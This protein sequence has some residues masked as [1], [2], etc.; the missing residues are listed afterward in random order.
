MDGEPKSYTIFNNSQIFSK[1]ASY[2]PLHD[3]K[4]GRLV[5]HNW[6]TELGPTLE[7]STFVDLSKPN[8]LQTLRLYNSSIEK[9]ETFTHSNFVIRHDTS[10]SDSAVY[11]V[12][13]LQ[14]FTFMKETYG[15][16]VKCLHIILGD[17][18]PGFLN[19]LLQLVPNLKVL[20]VTC[21]NSFSLANTPNVVNLSVRRK[22]PVLETLKFR[23]EITSQMERR[24]MMAT[25]LTV[26]FRN[27]PHNIKRVEVWDPAIQSGI[28]LAAFKI[29]AKLELKNWTD[30]R[31]PFFGNAMVPVIL[32]LNQRLSVIKV[33]GIYPGSFPS[34][35]RILEKH[36]ATLTI[37]Q[38]TL[39]SMRT[40]PNEAELKSMQTQNFDF[41][42]LPVLKK[43]TCSV[44]KFPQNTS[45]TW[46]GVISLYDR[47]IL[48]ILQIRREISTTYTV[49]FD[50]FWKFV[51]TAVQLFRKY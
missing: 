33:G 50:L 35:R 48:R 12:M 26:L 4:N 23:S 51:S 22:F 44:G 17:S 8:Y 37:L 42:R 28:G 20:E 16:E 36:S 49:R 43:M 38:V 39:G 29:V 24:A 31:I 10:S 41:P 40:C 25:L 2:L 11:N 3:L 14:L 13:I 46:E 27:C 47:A 21:T 18:C 9:N 45:V 32:G 34:L 19:R 15:E 1:I 7:K 30:L 6:A 5:C